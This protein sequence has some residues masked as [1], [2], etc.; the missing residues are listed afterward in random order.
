MSFEETN[1]KESFS[2]LNEVNSLNDNFHRIYF[3]STSFDGKVTDD[4]VNLQV[5]DKIKAI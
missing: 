4:S 3:K 5:A 1:T 2:S